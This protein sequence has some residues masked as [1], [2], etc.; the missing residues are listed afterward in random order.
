M[1]EMFFPDLFVDKIQDIDAAMLMKNGIKGL[2][3]DIDNTL[4]PPHVPE[5]D[6]NAL[7]WIENIKSK[8]V[9]VCIVSNA[10][11]KRVEKFNEKLKLFAV[12]RALKPGGRSFKEAM[13]AMGLK[14]YETAVVG[15]QVFT[16]IWGG[17]L[18]GMHTILVKPI[19]R[20]ESFFVRARRFMEN[21][22]LKRYRNNPGAYAGKSRLKKRFK[23]DFDD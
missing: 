1:I 18:I 22:I 5:A 11:K 10:A 17:N 14:P 15:D 6:K 13:K 3:L 20:D 12:H 9:K 16:D 19:H 8:G 4:V 23:G 21:I 2:I 7:H